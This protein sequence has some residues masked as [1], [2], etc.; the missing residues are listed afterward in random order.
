MMR[1]HKI[2]K[3]GILMSLLKGVKE[4]KEIEVLHNRIQG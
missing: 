2:A 4:K 1:D 3:K